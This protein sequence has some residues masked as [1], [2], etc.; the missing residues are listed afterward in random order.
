VSWS[1]QL[2]DEDGHPV[3]DEYLP[4]FEVAVKPLMKFGT[5]LQ[6][7]NLARLLPVGNYTLR[8]TFRYDAWGK[9]KE[10]RAELQFNA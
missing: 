5:K 8:V 6:S 9:Q 4:A 7:I 3:S 1:C 10:R 2:L